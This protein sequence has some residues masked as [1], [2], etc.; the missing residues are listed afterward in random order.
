MM[1]S[2][3]SVH[4]PGPMNKMSIKYKQGRKKSVGLS[5]INILNACIEAAKNYE[6]Y[7]ANDAY[8]D[9]KR[10]GHDTAHPVYKKAVNFYKNASAAGKKVGGILE[11]VRLNEGRMEMNAIDVMNHLVA[12]AEEVEGV[13][14]YMIPG[15]LSQSLSPATQVIGG[16]MIA[17]FMTSGKLVEATK[18]AKAASMKKFAR[19]YVDAAKY[20]AEKYTGTK[21][22]A[23]AAKRKLIKGLKAKD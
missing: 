10:Y 15:P 4:V 14:E 1:I 20:G 6:F 8:K 16:H 2:A 19:G 3:E 11:K 23:S 12:L 18:L 5:E 22:A 17:P 7:D 13:Q 21:S 9:M